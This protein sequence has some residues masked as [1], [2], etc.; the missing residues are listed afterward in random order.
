MTKTIIR[1]IGTMVQVRVEYPVL[2][3]LLHGYV[4][5]KIPIAKNTSIYQ[6]EDCYAFSWLPSANAFF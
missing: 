6:K 3:N 1:K 2:N 4:Y 5:E